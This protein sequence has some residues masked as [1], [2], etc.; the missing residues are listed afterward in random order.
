MRCSPL[1]F[2]R[3]ICF[4]QSADLNVNLIQHT[5]L[6]TSRVMFDEE[7]KPVNP[8]GN[9]SCLL[10]GRTVAEASIFWPPDVK[11]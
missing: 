1:H 7:I 5:L 4:I 3:A 6:E 8:K 2:K 10:F 11:N 9:Q